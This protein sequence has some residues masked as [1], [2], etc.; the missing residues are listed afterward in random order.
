VAGGGE[1]QFA[2]PGDLYGL[3]RLDEVAC[4]DFTD[5]AA[6]P[7]LGLAHYREHRNR[8]LLGVCGCKGEAKREK[9]GKMKGQRQMPNR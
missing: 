6:L 3:P 5:D 2:A 9:R 1:G 8:A 7:D 4:L